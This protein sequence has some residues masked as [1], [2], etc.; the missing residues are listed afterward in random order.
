MG[1][2]VIVP[3]MSI[4]VELDSGA[5]RTLNTMAEAA[6]LCV[7]FDSAGQADLIPVAAGVEGAMGEMLAIVFEAMA[8]RT[9]ARMKACRNLECRYVF[10]DYSKNRTAT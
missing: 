3:N 8:D 7:R 6:R 1:S 9:W 4:Y 2:R 5:I 10:Y